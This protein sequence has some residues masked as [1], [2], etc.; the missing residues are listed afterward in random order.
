VVCQ[1]YSQRRQDQEDKTW[2]TLHQLE[3]KYGNLHS[4][5]VC[6]VTAAI[7]SSGAGML[8]VMDQNC[9]YEIC[10]LGWFGSLQKQFVYIIQI[11]YL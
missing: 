8:I 10:V 11:R 9:G 3:A 2:R 7:L 6:K 5:A 4:H 1:C